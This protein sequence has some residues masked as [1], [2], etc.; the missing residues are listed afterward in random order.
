MMEEKRQ[1]NFL[2]QKIVLTPCTCIQRVI[3]DFVVK[4]CGSPTIQ[5]FQ[6]LLIS[7]SFTISTGM[8]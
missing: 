6:Y 1:A 4:Y 3:R 8:S 2:I 7:A 5:T